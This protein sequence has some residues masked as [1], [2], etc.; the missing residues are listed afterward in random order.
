MEFGVHGTCWYP[1]QHNYHPSLPPRRL[2][3]LDD[4][5]A[6]GA[7]VVA[8]GALGGGGISLAHLEEEAFGRV[9]SRS[10][11]YG[12]V[13]DSEFVQ[14]ASRRGIT[15]FGVCFVAQG[16]EFPA[17]LSEAEDE[18][19]ALNEMRGAGARVTVG[20][21]EFI[22]DRY[23][24]LWP[25]A[26]RW[27][28]DGLR[29]PDGRVVTDLIDAAAT[30]DIQG[31]P[32][33]ARWLMCPDREHVCYLMHP[34]SPVWREY[35]KAIV[36]VQIDAGVTGVQF[37]E[38]DAA[39]TGIGYGGCF[40][41]WC[42]AGFRSYL[43][44]L[45]GLPAE[46]AGVD[47]ERFDYREFLLERG[48]GPT[49]DFEKSP[50]FFHYLRFHRRELAANMRELIAYTREYARSKGRDV[51]IGANLLGFFDRFYDFV[52]DVDLPLSEQHRTFRQPAWYRYVSGFTGGRDVVA[53]MNPYT[54][55]SVIEL[56]D[57][58]RQGRSIDTY[59][60]ALYEA[61]AFGINLSVPYGA[62]MGSVVED[63]FY[64]PHDVSVAVNTFL[65]EHA[66]LFGQSSGADTAI[67]YS[68]EGHLNT[69]EHDQPLA[70]RNELW[71]GHG[72]PEGSTDE[73]TTTPFWK[74]ANRLTGWHQPIDVVFSPATSFAERLRGYRTIIV[75]EREGLTEEEED[76][77][78]A[79]GATVLDDVSDPSE[80]ARGPQVEMRTPFD[81]AL[82]LH[83]LAGGG[84]A[85]HLVRFSGDPEIV[86]MRLR[87]PE[88]TTLGVVADPDDRASASIDV[89]NET[90]GRVWHHIVV[91]N[92][93]LY[94]ILEL[95]SGMAHSAR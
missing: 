48:S 38:P 81:G 95:A 12:V 17:E 51:R 5:E 63:A 85:L 20:V 9:D 62:W 58:L 61:A 72:M 47:L 19:R 68:I 88:R 7:T 67:V 35:L 49:V 92:L 2:R 78:G 71:A 30:K 45:A 40:C 46:L 21:N 55:G 50:L 43:Q 25:P 10:R 89:E 37:D 39:F 14:E 66:H 1:R 3:Y 41:E 28:P 86:E 79:S 60:M 13:N 57:D 93:G 94:G 18:I 73:D 59:R 6:Y 31:R 54:G 8:W 80:L 69:L 90:D 24:K 29:Y 84:F 16:W 75:P 83:A 26:S 33:H 15:V 32:R 34:V 36:R 27:F 87:L 53:V 82:H 42:I 56:V 4:W 76:A 22:N 70:L 52:D 65:R 91:R 44:S 74:V 23:P 64:G 77:L 11:I